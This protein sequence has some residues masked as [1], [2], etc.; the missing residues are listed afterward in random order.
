[1]YDCY[2]TIRK[3]FAPGWTLC[4][5]KCGRPVLGQNYVIL[6]T[7]QSVIKWTTWNIYSGQ[8]KGHT[9]SCPSIIFG[10]YFVSFDSEMFQ[11][12]TLLMQ[13]EFRYTNY[14]SLNQ[15]LDSWS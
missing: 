5:H 8:P 14:L 2:Y 3:I 12:C 1:M 9:I 10:P 11:T 6:I 4:L 7:I 15:E 13:D